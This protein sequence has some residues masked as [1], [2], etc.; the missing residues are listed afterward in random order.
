MLQSNLQKQPT[1]ADMTKKVEAWRTLNSV[2]VKANSEFMQKLHG[3]LEEKRAL[4]KQL[5][6]KLE[7]QT[8]TEED[9]AEFLFISGYIKCLEDLLSARK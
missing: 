3:L 2:L 1:K 5:Q 6:E 7:D 9:N 4:H 8:G